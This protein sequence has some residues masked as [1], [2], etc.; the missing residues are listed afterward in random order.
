MLRELRRGIITALCVG[1]AGACSAAINPIHQQDAQTAVRV[2]TALVNDPDL[3]VLAIEV[4]VAAGVVTLS[5]RVRTQAEADRAVALVRGIPGVTGVT[6][7]LHVG[8]IDALPFPVATAGRAAPLPGLGRDP[9]LEAPSQRRWLAVG[10]NAG[11][12][13]PGDERLASRTTIGP[14]VRIG[15]G[16]GVSPAVGFGW[17]RAELRSTSDADRR[18]AQ[19]RLRPLMGGVAVRHS[20]DRV[21]ASVDLVAGVSFNGI[22][23]RGPIQVREV[24]VDVSSSFAWRPGVSVWMDLNGRFALNLSGGYVVTRPRLTMIEDGQ[25]TSRTLRADTLLVHVGLVYKVF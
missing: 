5:G 11:W 14:L 20:G 15:S 3:G 4:R 24:P 23:P 19:I 6:S 22:Q 16:S 25:V 1:V 17:Y 18:L 21:S 12:S 7:D 8:G 9:D 13:S 10:A 2:K